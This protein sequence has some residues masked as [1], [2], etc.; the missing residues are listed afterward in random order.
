MRRRLLI[1]SAVFG[2][3]GLTVLTASACGRHHGPGPHGMFHGD[4]EIDL[5]H[6]RHGARWML[7]SADPTDEQLDE[8]AILAKGAIEELR[9]LHEGRDAHRAEIAAAFSGDAVDR[10][11]LERLRSEAL[12]RMEDG[13]KQVV[14]VLVQVAEVLT[15][16]Q[17]ATLIAEHEK[18]RG[19]HGR[20]HGWH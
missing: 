8:I 13:S 1:G 11:A 4:E 6:L 3:L 20:G 18:R 5:D 14:E 12:A 15:P 16:E 9:G 17:R 2:L 10:D 19:S 7:R